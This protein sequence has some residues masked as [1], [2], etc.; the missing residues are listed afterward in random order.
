M[1]PH[2][3]RITRVVD[4][5]VGELGQPG[6]AR[7]P[8][9][10]GNDPL[11]VAPSCDEGGPDFFV[12][13]GAHAGFLAKFCCSSKQHVAFPWR[14]RASMNAKSKRPIN[15][16]LAE[17]IRAAMQSRHIATQEELAKRSG[18]SQRT[19]SNYLNPQNRARGASGKEPSA[20]LSEV[21]QIA[22]ALNVEAWNLLRDLS[23]S[24]RAFYDRIDEAYR[25]L[26][27]PPESS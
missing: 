3:L 17:N 23:P 11:P 18:L 8:V 2:Q 1:E 19:I 9:E 24:E 12:E 10:F 16:V 5:P 14:D 20:K 15:E 27:G 21:D 22:V 13:F 6:V 26:T 4:M 25:K 7:L